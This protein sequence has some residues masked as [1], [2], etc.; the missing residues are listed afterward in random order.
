M[1]AGLLELTNLAASA[2]GVTILRDVSLTVRPGEL[3]VLMGP[4]GSGKST[5]A[6]VLAGHPNYQVTGGTVQFCGEDLLA[7][8]PDVRARAGMFLAFQYPVS[9]PGVSLTDFL[10]AALGAREPAGAPASRHARPVAADTVTQT[11]PSLLADLRLHAEAANRDVNVDLSGGEKKK[12]ELAQLG[13]LQSKL[14]V[15]DEPD[16]GLDV[17]ALRSIANQI[18][19]HHTAGMAIILITHY[20]RILQ[21]LKPDRVHIMSAG[22]IVRSGGAQLAEEVERTGYDQLVK[23]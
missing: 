12:S 21:Y 23:A 8:S 5:L 19:R 16:S 1:N 15:L 2:G 7:M 20:N 6:S 4:N 9:V 3:H 13:V 10:V 18:S 22:R 11:L 14:A 17:D